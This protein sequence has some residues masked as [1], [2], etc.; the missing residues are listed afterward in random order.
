MWTRRD[1]RGAG[2]PA[3]HQGANCVDAAR[4]V[5]AGVAIRDSK[6]P[7]GPMLVTKAPG[8]A[9]S[10]QTSSPA[11]TT[12][13]DPD[14]PRLRR[15]TRSFARGRL[16]SSTRALQQ[17]HR[18][19]SPPRSA[20]LFL[21]LREAQGCLQPHPK[22]TRLGQVVTIAGDYKVRGE[23]RDGEY[24]LRTS[25]YGDGGLAIG[26]TGLPISVSSPAGT[27]A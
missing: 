14:R 26:G 6:N 5:G 19:C 10:S 9:P 1:R 11:P 18:C 13:P 23:P 16:A 22:P 12:S 24:A 7:G 17:G 21:H 20:G 27:A 3:P 4:L 25:A 2:A 15:R 8:G